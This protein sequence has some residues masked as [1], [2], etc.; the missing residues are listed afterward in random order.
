ML[1][2]FFAFKMFSGKK[3]TRH[4]GDE[5]AISRTTCFMFKSHEMDAKDIQVFFSTDIS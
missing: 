1:D 2:E 3:M 5:L 4:V